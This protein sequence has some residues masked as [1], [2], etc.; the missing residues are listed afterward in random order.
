MV[1]AERFPQ[2]DQLVRGDPAQTAELVAIDETTHV[3]IVTHGHLHD[4]DAL[5]SVARLPRRPPSA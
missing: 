4:T 1:T 3:V 5:R 2:A